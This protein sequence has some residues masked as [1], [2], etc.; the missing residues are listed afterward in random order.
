[1]SDWLFARYAAERP[2]LVAEN[3]DGDLLGYASFGDFRT[4]EGYAGTVEHTVYVADGA[5]RQGIGG[6][7][8]SSLIG[9]AQEKRLSAMI[10][11]ISADQA[12]SLALHAKFGFEE[13]GRLPGIGEKFGRRLDLVLMQLMLR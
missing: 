1:M 3:R 11:G 13:V 5:R 7:L 2:V 8:L 9:K 4:G 10:G 6:A 12:G